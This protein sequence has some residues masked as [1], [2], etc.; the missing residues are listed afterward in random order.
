M[1]AI[2][3][4]GASGLIGAAVV[5][6]LTQKS[7]QATPLVRREARP[8]EISWDPAGGRLDPADLEGLDGVIHLA[9]EPVGARWTRGR[10]ARIRD[11]RVRGTRLLSETLAR[12]RRK[13]EVMISASAIGIYGNRGEEVLTETS[14]PGDGAREFLVSVTQDWEAAADPARAA[15]IRVVHPRFGVVLSPRGGALKKLLPPFRL[16]L[17]GRLGNGSQ[18]MSWISIDDAVGAIL[19]LL[20]TGRVHGPVNTTALEPLTNREFTDKVGQ[21]LGRPTSFPVPAGALRLALGEM[22]D[23]TLLASTRVLPSRLLES[24][25][26][27][28]HPS[29]DSALR[30][31]LGREP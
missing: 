29:L 10:K 25:Y 3:V 20:A 13:P 17:G 30:H 26:R 15:G 28:Q 2:A 23:A 24:G 5:R 9:G 18:W 21:V 14:P 6:D 27:F 12:L 16:G 8:G 19:H 31:M 1:A 22:A 7:H 4:S 11:S